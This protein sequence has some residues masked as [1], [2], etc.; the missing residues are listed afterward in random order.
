MQAP[1]CSGS[2]PCNRR[3]R[4]RCS[5]QVA[6]LPEC[7]ELSPPCSRQVTSSWPQRM[8]SSSCS[9]T[10]KCCPPDQRKQSGGFDGRPVIALVGRWARRARKRRP[11]RSQSRL[12]RRM[13]CA[14]HRP[15]ACTAER[16]RVR[17]GPRPVNCRR[18]SYCGL[19]Q[20]FAI[21]ICSMLAVIVKVSDQ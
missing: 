6:K 19:L 8:M 18:V 21:S 11:G 7:T 13:R 14:S 17:S 20:V 16:E 3:R 12:R 15:G 4:I 10:M 5:W 2:Q 9:A 1:R